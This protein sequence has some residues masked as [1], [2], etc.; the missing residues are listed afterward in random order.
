ML[1][2]DRKLFFNIVKYPV[3]VIYL[4]SCIM[5]EFSRY[6]MGRCTD[7][8][9]KDIEELYK[10]LSFKMKNRKLLC[11]LGNQ[12]EEMAMS[13]KR[14]YARDFIFSFVNS[15]LYDPYLVEKSQMDTGYE[16]FLNGKSSIALDAKCYFQDAC[17]EGKRDFVIQVYTNYTQEKLNKLKMS[18]IKFADIMNSIKDKGDILNN[19]DEQVKRELDADFQYTY[20]V[21][22]TEIK[23]EEQFSRRID[24]LGKIYSLNGLSAMPTLEESD[25][26]ILH[27]LCYLVS[28]AHHSLPAKRISAILW[29]HLM[30]RPNKIKHSDLLDI[31]WASAY[32]PFIDYA[33]TDDDFCKLLNESGLAKEYGVKIYSFKNLRGLINELS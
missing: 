19:L 12:L 16:A 28:E 13:K 15:T 8:H 25:S 18:K 32:L 29:A 30:Q 2:I 9:I 26:A 17:C 23:D 11:P 3:P 4:D 31:L 5:I 6:C 21:L 7:S 33:V 24:E 14:K 22:N 27:F 10:L 20:S 1:H